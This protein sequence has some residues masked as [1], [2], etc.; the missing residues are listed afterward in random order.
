MKSMTCPISIEPADI[1]HGVRGRRDRCPI[2]LAILHDVP[3]VTGVDVDGEEATCTIEGGRYAASMPEE[4]D[5]FI[6]DFDRGL[7][8][9]PLTLTLEFKEY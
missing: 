4:G 8:V 5:R 9:R 6:L 2:A 1:E 3:G 7:A